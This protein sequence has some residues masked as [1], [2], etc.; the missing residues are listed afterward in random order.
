MTIITISTRLS[1]GDINSC[2]HSPVPGRAVVH[3][4]KEPCHRYALGYTAKT[5]ASDH[6]HYL[7]KR[8][9]SA[10]YLNLIDPPVPLFQRQSFQHFFDFTD[11]LAQDT[12]LHIHCNQ[13]QSRAPSLALLIMAKRLNA[14]PN[15]SYAAARA[16]F[17]HH[18]PYAPGK[19]LSV[20][21]QSEWHSLGLDPTRL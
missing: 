21:L 11:S 5:L 12:H 4:C 18:Y 17:S 13:G 8:T 6:Q 19:G 16:A 10:L 2:C 20:F 1:Y 14:L 15:D 9:P 3:A 7:A